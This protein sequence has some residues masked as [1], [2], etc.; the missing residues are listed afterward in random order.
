MNYV[1]IA[2][3]S[4]GIALQLLLIHALIKGAY[5]RFPV[6][7]V[8]AVTLFLTTVVEGAAFYDPQIYAKTS[9]Y[10][11]VIDAIRQ[12]LIF[13]LVISMTYQVMGASPRRS[14]VRRGLVLGAI[15][16]AVLSLYF[17]REDAFGF[18]M[19]RTSRNLGFFAVILNLILWAV[20][21]KFRHANKVLLLIS[22]GLGIQMAGKAIGHSLRQI[23]PSTRV[24]G[25]LL[26]VL[27]H[28]VCL[29]I[30]WQA[31]RSFDQESS[32]R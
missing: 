24:G 25:D 10:Y 1:W 5:R 2:L 6:L 19:T 22:G 9:T 26:I 28:L 12:V 29:Y 23:S 27:S 20:L 4:V 18:W 13:C 15:L 14:A 7:F 30:W 17:S 21:I 32:E 31:F 16:F 3:S 8:Y 11:W